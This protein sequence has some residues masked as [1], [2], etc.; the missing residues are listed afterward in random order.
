MQS[1]HAINFNFIESF[2][3]YLMY[4]NKYTSTF[5]VIPLK[6]NIDI[7]YGYEKGSA[8]KRDNLNVLFLKWNAHLLI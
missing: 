7:Q 4:M 5:L 1:N 6:S 8:L 2:A 3:K